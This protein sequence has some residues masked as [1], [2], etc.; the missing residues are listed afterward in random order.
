MYFIIKIN[1]TKMK[2]VAKNGICRERISDDEVK[3]ALKAE[4]KELSK[5]TKAL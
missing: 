3:K 2:E 4:E 1:H 5:D